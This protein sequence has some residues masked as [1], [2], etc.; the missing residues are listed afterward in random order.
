MTRPAGRFT[1]ECVG[2]DGARAERAKS[3]PKLGVGKPRKGAASIILSTGAAQGGTLDE[4]G[5]A[6]LPPHPE[7]HAGASPVLFDKLDPGSLKGRPH[8]RDSFV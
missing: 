1:R 7:T 3:S 2:R 8:G 4:G 6:R 5:A